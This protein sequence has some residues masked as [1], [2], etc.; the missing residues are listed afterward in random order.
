M[1]PL[2]RRSAPNWRAA[3]AEI[4]PACQTQHVT[5]HAA[6][7]LLAR[8]R[9]TEAEAAFR[10]FIARFPDQDAVLISF[11]D[12]LRRTG[13]E[14]EAEAVLRQAIHVELDRL[15]CADDERP[16]V[17]SYIFAA[18]RGQAP[19]AAS[20]P[21]FVAGLFDRFAGSFDATLRER[22]QYRAP[23]VLFEA[24]TSEAGRELRDLDVLDLGCGTG[25]AGEL[26]RPVARRLDGID[27]SAG[28]IEQAT[29]KN[30]YDRLVTGELVAFLATLDQ[31]YDLILA[32]DVFVYLGDL[33]PVFA[34]SRRSLRDTGRLAF[35][36]EL[37][38]SPG[39]H[40]QPTRRF[41]HH[42]DYLHETARSAGLDER[43]L[44][45]TWTRLQEG[46]P[47]RSW[48]CVAGAS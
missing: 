37:S 19:P 5:L 45:E 28:M 8:G 33:A 1:L 4:A 30:I 47:V 38:D 43:L 16:L 18:E 32:A 40:L 34:A 15:G 35:T 31:A 39:Y 48:V 44:D 27:L 25:L 7:L 21:V 12:L 42:R 29:T 26:F 3:L 41:V 14:T 9:L 20:P 36:V 10:E 24:V 11:A 46:R 2:D 23:E 6:N 17:E 13:R 22:L